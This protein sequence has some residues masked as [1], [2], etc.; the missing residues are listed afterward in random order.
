MK[1]ILLVIFMVLGSFA[2]AGT[3]ASPQVAA[4]VQQE[5]T[6]PTPEPEPSSAPMGTEPGDPG[7]EDG[8]AGGNVNF[9]DP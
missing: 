3:E 4:E 5:N 6:E 9:V 8:G 1:T 2:F 7:V